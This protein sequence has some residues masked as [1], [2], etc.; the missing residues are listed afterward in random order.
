MVKVNAQSYSNRGTD[1][2]VGYGNDASMYNS[3]GTVNANG[4]GQEMVLYFT[5]NRQ[6][7]IK[8]EIPNTG[9]V[10]YYTIASGG[11][12]VET[13]PLPKT[14]S[15]DARLTTEGVSNK[16]IHITSDIS[17]SAYSHIYSN[18]GSATALLVPTDILGQDY[19]TLSY[20]QQSKEKYAYSFGFVVATEDSTVVE[21]IP[22]VNTINHV[23]N[24]PFTETLNKG[25]IYN[26]F[27]STIS[28]NGGEYIA[29]D[30][31][32]TRIR[33]IVKD[34]TPCKK[35]AVFCGSG[36]TII[37]CDSLGRTEDNLFQQMYPSDAW[38]TRFV[39][40]PSQ[41]MT[42]N[43]YRVLV[44][45][46]STTVKVNGTIL[47]NLINKRYYEFESRRPLLITSD[48]DILVAQYIT[49]AKACGN[50][51]NGIDGDPD[52]IFL[53]PYNQNISSGK[54]IA[55]S[56]YATTSHY[57]NVVTAT[58][59]T[60]FFQLDGVYSG[61]SFQPIFGNSNF[62]YAQFKVKAGIH[63][64]VSD[65]SFSAIAYGYGP[66]ESYGYN[67]GFSLRHLL[68]FL[69]V[70]NPY[71]APNDIPQTCAA[72]PFKL[73]VNFVFKPNDIVWD[74]SNNPNLTPNN[75]V[76]IKNAVYDSVYSSHGERYYR[77][78]LPG[79]YM[80]NATGN[81][82]VVVNT[83]IP[84]QDGCT[85][86]FSIPYDIDVVPHPVADWKLNYDKCANDTLFF[87]DTSSAFTNKIIQWLWN[88]DDGTNTT[89]KNPVKKYANYGDYN[90]ALRIITDIGCYADTVRPISLS[91]YPIANF[92]AMP[93][94]EKNPVIFTDKST[95]SYGAITNWFWEFGDK[96]NSNLQN[97]PGKIY[98]V[99]GPYQIKLTVSN[100][101]GCTD[102]TLKN[103]F[104]Y[105]YPV[106]TT[107]DTFVYQGNAVQLKPFYS[108]DS[109]KYQWSPA[110]YLNSDTAAFPIAIPKD[111]ITYHLTVTGLG[112]CITQKDVYIDVLQILDVPNA[113]SPNG[114]GINDKWII[115]NLQYYPNADVQIFNRYGQSLFHS[116]NYYSNPW[117]GTLSGKP[118]PV[119]TYYY[120]INPK[121]PHLTT[122]TGYV[123]ILR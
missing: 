72:T 75:T 78:T 113:F 36:N 55:A 51:N 17:V 9:W 81:L 103:I 41:N 1:F 117:N 79:T 90:V 18:T 98:E 87:K 115:N 74:F 109:L 47:T 33:T 93:N 53:L 73:A 3:D 32:G 52:M 121:N 22:S 105:R 82:S 86:L 2:W 34:G 38:G 91:T 7:N 77:Y 84:T 37:S 46:S 25:E 40:V 45:N 21:I 71:G 43:Y 119:G 92:D 5:C 96:E 110:L 95:I 49:G 120:I 108:G 123:L 67:V 16:G 26:L 118:L 88:F 99:G 23:A 114:D 50:D 61:G 8:V 97:P 62:S 102:D 94:C 15:D 116:T 42:N 29:G 19:Y 58:T 44:K 4:G 10:K 63:S 60:A 80:Y 65:S 89:D 111:D 39:T 70:Q 31:T 76:T 6:A 85:A 11:G 100:K 48:N 54:V 66:G 69:Q 14:G 28:E 12:M 104:I 30:I 107:K 20:T 59:D 112:G 83:Y 13:D 68:N 56:H 27:G 64:L 57:I 122:K 101:N 106:V 24:V 35:I